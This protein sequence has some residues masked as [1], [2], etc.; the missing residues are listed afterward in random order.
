MF[1][2]DNLN[3]ISN[4]N[5]DFFY[6]GIDLGST[7]AKIAI[8]DQNQKLVFSR[9][10]RHNTKVKETVTELLND[11]KKHFG[12]INVSLKITGSAGMGMSE[13]TGIPFV[14]EVIASAAVVSK[15]YPE[16][17]TL[18]DIGGED[19][20]MIF[21]HKNKAPDIRMNGSCAGG[22]GAFIDQMASLLNVSLEKFNQLAGNYKRIYPIASRCGVFAKTDVQNLLSRKVSREDIAAS[23]FHAVAIQTINTLARGYDIVH[24]IIFAGG[25]FT[26]L[27]ELLKTFIKDLKLNDDD[28]Q[29][30]ENPALL[31]SIG[32][33][34]SKK[35]GINENFSQLINRIKNPIN[36]IVAK[37]RLDPLFKDKQDL[38]EWNKK[39]V[40]F[41]VPRIKI[42]KMN[43]NKCYLGIDSGSTTTK[44]CAIDE[45]KKLI[46]SYYANTK[47]N[48][49]ES[50]KKGLNEFRLKLKHE[51]KELE[52][53]QTAVV[54]Y[55]EDL[56]KSALNLDHGMV[57][58][59]AHFNAA[60]F[61]NDKVSF[62]L[63]IG[64]QDMK[65]IFVE[66]G[67][68]NRIE[69]NESC[70]AGCGS[71]IETFGN[72]LGYSVQDFS[73]IA[74]NASAPADLGTRCTVFMNSKVKQ[75]LRE[76]ATTNDI[77]AGLSISVIKNA[78][79][80]VLKMKNLSETG[81]HIVV[82][83]GA[84]R[85]PSIHRALEQMTDKKVICS[86]I[87]EQ[88]GAYG[89]AIFALEKTLIE[90]KKT[91]FKG[92]DKLD[93]LTE[94]TTKEIQCKGCENNCNISKFKFSNDNIFFSGNKC[95]KYFFNKGSNTT[96]GENL[97]DFK[98]K[99]LFDRGNSSQSTGSSQQSIS[100]YRLP[101]IGIPRVLNVYENFPFW[102]ALFSTCGIKLELS[103]P[104]TVSLYEKGLGSVMS[105]SIC[106]PA[107]NVHGHINN[108]I[109]K[110]VDRIFFPM[111]MYEKNEFPESDN[112]FNCPLVS[113][114]ADVVKS[115]MDPEGRH[116]IPV[117]A[118]TF[119][120]N[121][122][123]LLQKACIGYL[124]KFNIKTDIIKKALQNALQAHIDFKNTLQ[125]ETEKIIK[126]AKK[127]KRLVIVLAGRPYH[128]DP[129]INQKTPEALSDMGVD[130]ITEDALPLCKENNLS[131]LQIISQWSYT[132]RIYNAAQWVAHQNNYF[133][134]VMLNS[135]GCGPDS[136]VID[137]VTEILK[138]KG[139]AMTLIRVDEISSTGS[140]RLRLRSMI[141]SVQMLDM[142]RLLQEEKRINTPEFKKEDKN[143][144]IIAPYFGEL[145]GELMPALFHLAGYDMINLPKPDKNSVEY[146]LKYAHNEIC[147]PATVVVGDILKALDTNKYKR[148]DVA[149]AIT[150]TGGQCR[151]SS[152]LSLIKKGMI[153]AGFDDI[154]VVALG[155][156]GKSIN[157]QEGFSIEWKKI[158]K[159]I[160]LSV[161]YADSIAKIYYWTRV[162]EKN[163]G[164]T[165]K[166]ANECIK[167]IIPYIEKNEPEK[168]YVELENAVN[169]FNKIDIKEGIYP[170]IG[171]VGEIYVKYN[172]FGHQFITDWLVD[173]NIEVIVPPLVDFLI[174]EFVNIEVNKK[175]KLTKASISDIMVYFLEKKANRYIK[176]I[177]KINA[178]FRNFRPFHNIR[179][180][181]DKASP[182]LNL[183]AQFGEGW[184]IPAEI[185]AFAEDG[186][187]HVVSVQPFGCIANHVVS[188]GV[189]KRIKGLFPDMSLLFLDFDA[190]T[191][192]V[193]VLNRLHFMVE[194]VFSFKN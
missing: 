154:P 76:N 182:I 82:Q 162:R 151:A 171:I 14:Q 155:T 16:V 13:S 7:T 29:I 177:E 86:D 55:G 26:F 119:N 138:A 60:K 186:V 103:D 5:K 144:K 158:L 129:L 148:E 4:S 63:D 22:T 128:T 106:F 164:E 111:A 21:F 34:I 73:K 176:K 84:F 190:D 49:I 153:S 53:V 92:L 178:K 18:I 80:K 9:Y 57:E 33:A 77:A 189:E 142:K 35:D 27:S 110:K 28:V 97:F 192:E 43:S 2:E 85:N 122:E 61:F 152:Y 6:A 102:H 20:K 98:Y 180:L 149:V 160:F 193:N 1:K 52:I 69:L 93:S 124:K 66:N 159:V 121:D 62:V 70:S 134:L 17:K 99:Q 46:F 10:T 109:G 50:A 163:K 42:D 72:S 165:E 157:P 88:M 123:K 116:N 65:A 79:F 40:S 91:L 118:P 112:T 120:F 126:E 167:A 101:I 81:D 23:V 136:I 96:K 181:A 12:D 67:L 105:D 87:P 168:I 71:F 132:N 64:G 175:S 83:G 56:I 38:E 117:D 135:F 15:K 37:N 54:G 194:N 115:S 30:T 11:A 143:R 108:L 161:L 51:K 187:N 74:C 90:N 19:S 156:F 183:A 3:S 24:K 107:K 36:K 147:F 75:S 44:I 127:S 146:G 95:E 140:I 78:L 39:K 170:T 89:A 100:N 133:Q 25:P 188:K 172:A 104:S 130:V 113:S 184:L 139:K 137:E 179:D 45:N 150:Q 32:A 31:P 185:A 145:Y 173:Q 68:I 8:I 141:E 48:P 59:I 47:G 191:S 41:Q 174:Q 166:L 58:T 131:D 114:Y 94:Y 125:N 169:R